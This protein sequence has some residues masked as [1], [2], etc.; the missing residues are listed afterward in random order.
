MEQSEPKVSEAKW[1]VR[2]C[3]AT[4]GHSPESWIF[5]E[6]IPLTRCLRID[7]SHEGRGTTAT[8][9]NPKHIRYPP[10]NITQEKGRPKKT[11]KGKFSKE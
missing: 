1:R 3:V 11:L 9:C 7:L 8:A 4:D 2:G 10:Q 5:S 6:S